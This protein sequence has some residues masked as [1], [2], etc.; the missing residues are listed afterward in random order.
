MPSYDYRCSVCDIEFEV[1]QSV[2]EEKGATCTKCNSWTVDRL[3]SKGGTF[4]L[5][6]DGWAADNYS[7][8]Q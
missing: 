7:K 3:I 1:Q 4:T 6:G 8:K 5:K 2:R